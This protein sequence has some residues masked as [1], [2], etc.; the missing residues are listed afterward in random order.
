MSRTLG[1]ARLQRLA[2]ADLVTRWGMFRTLVFARDSAGGRTNSVTTLALCFGSI[3]TGDVP[4]V[5]IHSRCLTADLFGSLL[6]DCAA[7][8]DLALLTIAREGRGIV[9]CEH[10]E[11]RGIAL[12][13]R[14]QAYALQDR[15][16]GSV[17]AQHP[18]GFD[19]ERDFSPAVA[20]LRE[21]GV[22]R[23]RLLSNNPA[24]SRA[25][26]ERGIEVIRRVTYE[27]S[28]SEHS[29]LYPRAKALGHTLNLES[30]EQLKIL[31]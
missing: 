26:A 31:S 29:R 2:A 16:L 25:L 4:L 23:L 12:I 15:G 8:L 20:V 22:L 3:T 27:G 5:H 24:E 6:C 18:L 17:E 1:A 19:D 28:P 7:Q 10:Q 14:L 13:A 11:G 30:R 9:L 21:L